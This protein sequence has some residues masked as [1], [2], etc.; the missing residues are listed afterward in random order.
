MSRQRT[1]PQELW[2]YEQISEHTGVRAGTLRVWRVRGHLPAP[3][4]KVGEYLAWKPETVEH[5]W[6]QRQQEA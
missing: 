2:S 4:F 6:K 3:D 5:W 1:A